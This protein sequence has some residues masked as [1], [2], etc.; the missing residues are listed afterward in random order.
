MPQARQEKHLVSGLPDQASNLSGGWAEI[1]NSVVGEWGLREFV[2]DDDNG[3]PGVAKLS[4]L[5]S[6]RGRPYLP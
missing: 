3:A 5:G 4:L 1:Y 2:F 6:L